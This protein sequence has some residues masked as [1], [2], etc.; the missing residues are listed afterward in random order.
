MEQEHKLSTLFYVYV[1]TV[2][3][4]LECVLFHF[5]TESPF[6]LW[7]S[8]AFAAIAAFAAMHDSKEFATKLKEKE[9]N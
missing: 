9:S 5:L 4:A 1:G 8:L 7:S 2:L 3:I 6:F